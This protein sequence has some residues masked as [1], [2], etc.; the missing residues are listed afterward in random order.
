MVYGRFKFIKV[1]RRHCV[2]TAWHLLNY[3]K[4]DSVLEIFKKSRTRKLFQKIKKNWCKLIAFVYLQRQLTNSVESNINSKINIKKST[5][6]KMKLIKK[7]SNSKELFEQIEQLKTF[8]GLGIQNSA[9]DSS[10]VDVKRAHK[11]KEVIFCWVKI[12]CTNFLALSLFL[13]VSCDFRG[14]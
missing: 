14:A 9:G 5:T 8:C 2:W 10:N 4:V 6:S 11:V 12:F 1:L 7:S 3:W 13:I